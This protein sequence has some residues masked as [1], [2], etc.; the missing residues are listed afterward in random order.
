LDKT[1]KKPSKPG[2]LSA[3]FQ[4]FAAVTPYILKTMLGNYRI[5]TRSIVD[6]AEIA[7][8]LPKVAKRT[9]GK[10]ILIFNWRDLRHVHAGGAEVYVQALGQA[11]SCRHALLRQ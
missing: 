10:N 9:Q 3:L 5:L 11:G 2:L 7:F 4:Q 8:P 1:P 6:L